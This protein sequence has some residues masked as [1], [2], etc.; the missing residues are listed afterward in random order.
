VVDAIW[1]DEDYRQQ[2][3]AAGL[4]IEHRHSPLGQAGE[5]FA[6][7]TETTISPWVIYVVRSVAT[8]S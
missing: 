5:P 8:S 4:E 6:W 1:F 7:M 2:F 3:A